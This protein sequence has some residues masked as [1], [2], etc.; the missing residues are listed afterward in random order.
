MALDITFR[1]RQCA[2]IPTLQQALKTGELFTM[3]ELQE[4]RRAMTEAIVAQAE[5]DYESLLWLQS[6]RDKYSHQP[7][8]STKGFT[9]EQFLQPYQRCIVTPLTEGA[10]QEDLIKYFHQK[11]VQVG[12]LAI[13]SRQE[14]L[15]IA[16]NII[17]DLEL[18]GAL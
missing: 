2:A 18:C 7:Q 13:R 17:A 5:Y 3:Q 11:L 4:I 9:R 10:T 6:V 1:G 14:R 8:T 16:R 15:L 12:L